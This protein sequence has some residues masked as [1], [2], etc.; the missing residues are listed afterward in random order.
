MA[1][2]AWVAAGAACLG[3]EL[4]SSAPSDQ[5]VLATIGSSSITQAEVI[6]QDPAAFAKQQQQYEREMRQLQANFAQARHDL[7]QQKLDDLLN[8]RALELEATQRRI[9]TEAVLQDVTVPAVTDADVRAFYEENKARTTLSFE[10]LAPRIREYL[11]VQ[12]NAQATRDFYRRLRT[13]FA[14]R[15]RLP[16]YRVAVAASGPV[17]GSA[18]APVTIIEFGDFQCPYCREAEAT[19]KVVLA[20]YPREVRLVFR[21]LPLTQLHPDAMVAAEA[22]ICADQQGK[23]WPMHDAMYANQSALSL[24]G[25]LNTAKELGLDPKRLAACMSEPATRQRIQTDMDAAQDLGIGGTPY[26]FV[27]GRPISGSVPPEKFESVVSEELERLGDH[28]AGD[29][30]PEPSRG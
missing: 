1:P 4:P 22:G 14:I 12:N 26:F 10:Q 9:S 6:K 21:E 23:F 7:L 8:Q 15:S 2:I 11:A 18:D 30:T 27:D 25:L 13:K 17:R 5:T 24:E 16:P 29:S 20:K 28:V 3:A 19:L